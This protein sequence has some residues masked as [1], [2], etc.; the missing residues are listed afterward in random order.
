MSS[1]QSVP[2]Q[3]VAASDAKPMHQ[4]CVPS[5]LCACAVSSSRP[6]QSVGTSQPFSSQSAGYQ[7]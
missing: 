4:G 2:G 7:T 6:G 5:V 3:P 1:I